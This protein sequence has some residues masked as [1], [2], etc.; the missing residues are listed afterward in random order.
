MSSLSNLQWVDFH[1]HILDSP[2]REQD[3]SSAREANVARW[4]I[5]SVNSKNWEENTQRAK[6]FPEAFVGVGFHPEEVILLSPE[7]A[8]KELHAIAKRIPAAPFV[9]ETG[10]DFLYGKTREH[11]QLQVHIFEA[12][13]RVAK[14]NKKWVSVHTR[15]A[16]QESIDVLLRHE[17]KNVHLHWFSGNKKQIQTIIDNQWICS[18]GPTILN[19]PHVDD[20]IE[21][22]PLELLALETDSPIPFD[23]TSSTPAWIPRV[24]ERLAQLKGAPLQD[25]SRAQMAI[26]ERM[27]PAP[28]KK[29]LR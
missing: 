10:L 28:A 9:G 12:L 24:A 20:F 6:P 13:L 8:E 23:G 25:V 16:K 15:H 27:F 11:Q 29:A 18:I 17:M 22:M 1:T 2:S 3:A 7:K 14:K 19:S 4:L 21:R 5:N 26:F